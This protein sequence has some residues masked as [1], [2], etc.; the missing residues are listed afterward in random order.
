[1]QEKDGAP[2]QAAAALE[3]AADAMNAA[4]QVLNANVVSAYRAGLSV[5]SI[6]HHIGLHPIAVRNLLDAAGE[7]L[8]PGWPQPGK[9]TGTADCVGIPTDGPGRSAQGTGARN[10]AMPPPSP[11]NGSVLV[12]L[13]G[14]PDRIGGLV[15]LLRSL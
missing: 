5:P 11:R 4:R 9:W 14:R 6:A 7:P 2:E 13:L 1:M 3:E 8:G 12:V 15:V 10:A